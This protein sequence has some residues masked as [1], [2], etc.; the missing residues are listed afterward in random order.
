[1]VVA[2]SIVGSRAARFLVNVGRA[3]FDGQGLVNVDECL[4]D[5][6]GDAW[7]TL[8]VDRDKGP[9]HGR[10]AGQEEWSALLDDSGEPV[11]NR[12]ESEI[13]SVVPKSH[14]GCFATIG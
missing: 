13:G 3:T 5:G 6:E 1:M 2:L 7:R 10:N 11:A 8:K 9:R 12:V 4:T 14:N